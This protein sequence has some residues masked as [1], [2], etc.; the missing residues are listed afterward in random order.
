MHDCCTSGYAESVTR[1]PEYR[2]STTRRASPSFRRRARRVFLLAALV[3]SLL[4]GGCRFDDSGLQLNGSVDAAPFVDASP[5][6]DAGLDPCQEW[7]FVP[8][9]FNPCVIRDP[10]GPLVL[11]I[12]DDPNNALPFYLYDTT[13]GQLLDPNNQL[14]A[15]ESQVIAMVPMFRLI[16]VEGLTVGP[17][18]TLRV[19]GD[20]GLL[21]ASWNDIDI[22]GTID[23]SS[24]ADF[25]QELIPPVRKGAGANPASCS[26]AGA[27]QSG[28][29]DPNDGNGRGSGGG[30][31]GF[32]AEGG[33]GGTTDSGSGGAGGAALGSPPDGL[34][35]GCRGGKGGDGTNWT[36]WPDSGGAGGDGGGALYLTARVDVTVSSTGQLNAG[37]AGGFPGDPDFGGNDNTERVGGGGGGSGGLLGLEGE[38]VLLH[39]SAMLAANGG[40]GGGGCHR[41]PGAPGEDGRPDA[42]GA[43]GGTGEGTP[44]GSGGFRSEAQGEVGIGDIGN[45][46]GGGGGGG[47]GYIVLY[48]GKV[49]VEPNVVISPDY[50]TP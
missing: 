14:L 42:I 6:A 12:P 1:I 50:S 25:E 22:H 34:Q 20:H 15:H 23:V 7:T 8:R 37:G 21:V 46:G 33:A 26:E 4:A 47:V 29:T 49:S 17:N 41:N 10:S 45:N 30:G 19:I 36:S 31:G 27:G 44:G 48:G 9:F 35:G 43:N 13:S 11:N 18:T 40:G 38:Q 28:V 39:G 3:F 32:G 24:K 16:S 5:L 2:R